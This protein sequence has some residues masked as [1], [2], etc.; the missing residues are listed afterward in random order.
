MIGKQQRGERIERLSSE[1]GTAIRR[2]APEG[3]IQ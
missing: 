1:C 3:E 2:P